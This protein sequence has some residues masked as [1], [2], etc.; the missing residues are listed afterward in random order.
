MQMYSVFLNLFTGSELCR[1]EE[2]AKAL[3]FYTC[4]YLTAVRYIH[5]QY[6]YK[7]KILQASQKVR[8]SQRF[9]KIIKISHFRWL[10][11]CWTQFPK[12]LLKV[13]FCEKRSRV[14]T[15][16]RGFYT[17]CHL[18][19]SLE[20]LKTLYSRLARTWNT[21]ASS[22]LSHFKRMVAR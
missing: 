3:E 15:K 10:S 16:K 6:F 14:T 17:S 7:S 2:E 12:T 20:S 5:T 11:C 13:L 1:V 8:R 4:L 19:L 9:W 22:P 21:S 18:K